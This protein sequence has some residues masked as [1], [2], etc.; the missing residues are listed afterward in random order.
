M[1][2]KIKINLKST[3]P[4]VINWPNQLRQIVDG[5]R[6]YHT[7]AHGIQKDAIQNSW[8][9]R[10]DKSR[11]D[12]WNI[13]FELIE[14]QERTF[15]LF[16]DQGTT[17][18]TGKILMPDDLE[19]DL[20]QEERWG[21]FENV[22]FTKE[23][24]ENALGSRGRGKFIFLGGS[25]YK[26]TIDGKAISNLIIYDTLRAD[27]I[28]RMGFRTLTS[29]DSPVNAFEGEEGKS[30]WLQMLAGLVKPIDKVGTRVIIVEPLNE[31]IKEIKDGI[32]LK[33][34][35]ETWWKIL[36]L[37]KAE[38]IVKIGPIKSKAQV[39]KYFY[40]PSSESASIKIWNK[41][42]VK[43]PGAPNYK[44]SNLQIV[45][46]ADEELP[47]DIR[48]ISIQRGGMKVCSIPVKYVDRSL[49]DRIY[50]YVNFDNNLEERLREDEGPEHYSY[51]F[52]KLIPRLLRQFIEEESEKFARE[53]LGIEIG[54][55]SKDYE[56]SKS[57]EM[58]AMY[59]INKIAMELGIT[60][61]G[62]GKKSAESETREVI[63]KPLKLRMHL[64]EFP[65]ETL[66]VN[67]G[68]SIK[69]I[70][71]S[72][73]NNT[74][75]E[76]DVGVRFSICFE[77]QTELVVFI[78]NQELHLGP[79]S[80][81]IILSQYE[82]KITKGIFPFK[83][84]HILSG[85]LVSLDSSNKGTILHQVNKYFWIEENPP[86]RGIFEDIEA[87]E[88]PKEK[89]SIMGFSHRSDSGGYIFSY[90]SLH[91]A[92]RALEKDENGLMRYLIE[93]MCIELAWIDLRS[94]DS[95]LYKE[96]GGDD[97]A[98]IIRTLAH[99][100]GDVRSRIY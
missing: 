63:S 24:S 99:F 33:Y 92:K 61:H 40:F 2:E 11:G 14:Y 18:L 67:Y 10:V 46:G 68:Q 95:K 45:Y 71:L 77:D 85:R 34:I 76:H 62:I 48:G 70:G 25:M 96:K 52:K 12:G 38:I 42:N 98:E 32:F 22:A 44:I 60:G 93:L 20:P 97:P 84:R 91:P 100:L 23:P 16:G 9:A 94:S 47:E 19:K 54:N 1:S 4:T 75:L 82:Q 49:A 72:I 69:N 80:N 89:L 37:Y 78:E 74:H 31:I 79:N 58:K 5:Y 59:Q 3:R 57:A 15:L 73:I 81:S 50:G 39:Q 27:G 65:G 90:N 28:Y 86:Q 13:V 41:T 36:K 6:S 88:F 55:K 30:E 83:G 8:D 29:T 87:V 53:K 17:G 43:L 26:D 21:R 7:I 66:R 51:D 56:K 35:E 64:V